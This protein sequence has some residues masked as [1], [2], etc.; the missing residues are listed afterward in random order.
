MSQPSSATAQTAFTEACPT[1][2]ADASAVAALAAILDAD[3]RSLAATAARVAAHCSRPRV[4]AD[5]SQLSANL[6][7]FLAPPTRHHTVA[8]AAAQNARAVAWP[9]S[10]FAVERGGGG[11]GGVGGGV[12]G[13]AGGGGA[14][15]GAGMAEGDGDDAM[16][17]LPRELVGGGLGADATAALAQGLSLSK[18]P[19][20]AGAGFDG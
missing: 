7:A 6:H 15:A 18:R 3:G 20:F 14:G 10:T 1:L 8:Y 19:R 11:G 17:A 4:D 2:H 12:G 16:T 5:I 9:S 13:D